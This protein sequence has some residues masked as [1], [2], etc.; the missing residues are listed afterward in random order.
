MLLLALVSLPLG[1]VAPLAAGDGTRSLVVLASAIVL[2]LSWGTGYLRRSAPLAMDV[3]DT[4]VMLAFALACP[5]PSVVLTVVFAALWFRCM[6]GSG[7]RAV[8]RYGLYVG[9]ILAIPT[10]WPHVLGHTGGLALGPLF[11]PL[12]MMLLVL[13]VVRHLA[14]ILHAGART[15]LIDAVHAS[16][17]YQLLRVSDP[18]EIRKIGW[19]AT[20]DICT[21]MAGLRVMKVVRAGAMLRVEYATSGF[22]DVPETL[23]EAVLTGCDAVGGTSPGPDHGRAELDVAVGTPC[24]WVCVPL[25]EMD[26]QPEGAW[27]LLGSPGRVPTEA[28]VAVET[29]ANQV[30]LALRNS[31]MHQKL[32]EQATRDSLTGLANGMSFNAALSTTVAA[33][34]ASETSVLYV[35]ID[36]FKDVN[37]VFGHRAG[38]SVL[39][40]VAARLRE[41]TRP[42]DL[43]ARLGGDEFAVLLPGTGG[44]AAAKVAQRIVD[45]IAA[46]VLV[47]GGVAH[48][49]ASVGVATAKDVTDVEQLVHRADVAMYAA[50]ANGKGTIRIFDTDLLRVDP[51]GDPG[52]SRSTADA[53]GL[54]ALGTTST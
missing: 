52:G 3:L 24:A 4:V 37:D 5:D 11:G 34:A 35:D 22:A 29:L 21:A 15:A 45:L 50:K 12:P 43:C 44:A 10:I 13:I 38:D 40:E 17:G 32:S 20:G 53:F 46:P 48:V 9:A 39:G 31:E 30:T 16:V 1:L 27:L 19:D 23:S 49:G 28:V 36:D 51:T 42:Q 41:A 14:G 8:L 47:V 7:Q 6:Y 33:T 54:G 25:P 18:V 2:A 26:N